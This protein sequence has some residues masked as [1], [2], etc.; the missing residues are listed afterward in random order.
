M[1]RGGR[2]QPGKAR[3]TRYFHGHRAEWAAGLFLLTKGYVTLAR[4]Y[5]TNVG[6]LD[7]I[8]RRGRTV[9]FCEVK[10]RQS[11]ALCEA[12]IT[13]RQRQRVRKA[14]ALW[15]AKHPKYQAYDLHF[16][17]VFLTP[18]SMPHHIENGL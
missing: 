14:A 3:T 7:L 18:W 15:L 6:E 10:Y 9:R 8:V 16:D 12:S 5:R 4:R 13:A 11:L 17:L 2:Q 1:T